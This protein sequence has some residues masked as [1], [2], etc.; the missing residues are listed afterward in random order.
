ME[1]SKLIDLEAR[2][3]GRVS[4]GLPL[5]VLADQTLSLDARLLLAAVVL[6]PGPSE[7]VL[8]VLDDPDS[9]LAELVARGLV[10]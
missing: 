6:D 4:P 9:A 3:R 5:A 10:R 2:R 7:R 1:D 8:K